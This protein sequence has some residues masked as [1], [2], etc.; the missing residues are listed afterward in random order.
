ML[1]LILGI[2]HIVVDHQVAESGLR[3]RKL[4]ILESTF[5]T[6]LESG[7][8]KV[9]QLRLPSKGFLPTSFYSR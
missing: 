9:E 4:T 5:F 3:L 1:E 2:V 6:A 7:Q 8:R